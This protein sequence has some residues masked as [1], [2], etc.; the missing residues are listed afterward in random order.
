MKEPEMKKFYTTLLI[1]PL[2]LAAGTLIAGEEAGKSP[3]ADAARLESQAMLEEADRARLEA[4]TVRLEAT[5]VA[6]MARELAQKQAKQAKEDALRAHRDFEATAQE[7]EI[8]REEM[9][10]AREQLS[11]AHREL[12]EASREVARA[13]RDLSRSG[14]EIEIIQEINLGDRAVIGVVMGRQTEQGVEIIGVS[15]DGPAE[16]AGIQPGDVLVSIRGEQLAADESARQ[17]VFQ[18]MREVADGEELAVEVNR[19]GQTYAYTVTAEQREPRGWQSIIRIPEELEQPE[20]PYVI[21]ETIEIPEIDEEALAARIAEMQERIE[22]T[23]QMFVIHDGENVRELDIEEFSEFGS[24]AMDE[25]NI[26]FGLPQGQG[27]ELAT[28]NEG[29][30]AYFKTDRGVLVIKAREGNDYE[31]ESGDV[32]LSIGSTEVNSPSDMRRALRDVEPGGEIAIE[33]KRNRK[34]RT[35]TV[36]VPENRL[37]FQ[38]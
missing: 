17:S 32:I 28:I 5:K 2:L 15:P 27:L 31:L 20:V 25:A 13:H 16:R 12:R 1:L 19:K 8:Q 35:L 9:S 7:R 29:L 37:G 14:Q 10:R 23:N 24:H 34:S 30:G 33:I 22:A 38:W 4:E 18:V 11:Q 21:T 36:V 26:W 3:S 6:Q